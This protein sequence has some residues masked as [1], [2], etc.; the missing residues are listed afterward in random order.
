M[1]LGNK[2]NVVPGIPTRQR[3]ALMKENLVNTVKLFEG[4][5]LAQVGFAILGIFALVAIFAPLIAPHPPGATNRGDDGSVLRIEPPMISEGY[6]LGTSQYG[7]DLFS[8]LVWS[9][10]TSL[11]VG[12]FAAIIAVFVGMNVALISAYYGGRVDSVLMRITDIAYG[13]PFLPFVLVL[14]F[15][16]EP[17]LIN[18]VFAI[19]LLLWRDTARVVRSEVLSQKERPYVEAA[20]TVGAS[21]VRIMYKHILPNVAPLVVLYLAFAVAYAIIFEASVAFLGFSDPA[22]FSWGQMMFMAYSTGAISYAW[23]WVLPPGLC[24][25]LTVMA[26]FFIGRSIEK[27]ANTDLRY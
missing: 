12:F 15:I 22:I 18:M 4:E 21:N 9:A 6:Y 16:F 14:V 23:W 8:Q 1:S 7:Q 2:L 17:S 5:R 20:R 25:M 26:V 10:R 3:W 19:A 13:L 24:I 11:F 27:V